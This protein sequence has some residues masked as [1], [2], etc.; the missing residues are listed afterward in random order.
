MGGYARP[1]LAGGTAKVV[2]DFVLRCQVCYEHEVGEQS[3]NK[4]ADS[5]SKLCE[6]EEEGWRSKLCANSERVVIL[7]ATAF[8]TLGSFTNGSC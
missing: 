6:E 7:M 3:I 1:L 2:V 5:G 4:G 8:W